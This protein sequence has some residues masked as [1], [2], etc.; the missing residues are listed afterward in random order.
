MK[1]VEFTSNVASRIYKDYLRRVELNSKILSEDDKKD[2]LMEI[3]SHIYE[4][5]QITDGDNESDKLLTI[6][7][8]LGAPEVFLKPI[9]AEKKINEAVRSFK[10]LDIFQAII[11]N[12]RNGIVY[13]VFALLYLFLTVFG[14][15]IISKILFPSNTGLFYHSNEFHSFGFVMNST[16]MDEVLGYWF[17]PIVIAAA[18]LFYVIITLLLRFIGTKK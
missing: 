13:S 1:N 18:V 6:I 4:G 12:L 10:P 5:M 16:G 11:L 17:Y 2:I 14:I 15:L 8:K 9:L 7:E 3:N